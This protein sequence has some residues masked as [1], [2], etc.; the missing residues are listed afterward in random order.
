MATGAGG[1][2]WSGGDGLDGGAGGV[3]G[4]GGGIER[5]AGGGRG[6]I[7]GEMDG[8]AGGDVGHGDSGIACG[9]GAAGWLQERSGRG[10]GAWRCGVLLPEAPS[11]AMPEA[12]M[13]ARKETASKVRNG[14]GECAVVKWRRLAAS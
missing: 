8:C 10:C 11:Q 14:C 1:I 9:D 6:T 2:T 4:E 13:A 3:D 7:G 12:R 5:G